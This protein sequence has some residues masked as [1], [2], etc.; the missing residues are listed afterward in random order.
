MIACR[1]TLAN[2]TNGCQPLDLFGTG[3]ASQAAKLNNTWGPLDV[4]NNSIPAVGYLDLRASYKWND[5]IQLYGAI[6]NVINAPPP[7]TGGSSA[8]LNFYDQSIRDDIYDATGR[9]YR[10]GVRVKY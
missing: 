1:S 3:V 9:S 5:N 8:V 4:D 2:S 10:I 6:D 7:I